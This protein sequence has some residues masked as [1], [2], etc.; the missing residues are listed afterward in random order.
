AAYRRRFQRLDGEDHRRTPGPSPAGSECACEAARGTR[1]TRGT[2]APASALGRVLVVLPNAAADRSEGLRRPWSF[3][4][5]IG[6]FPVQGLEQ[7]QA[8]GLPAAL[9]SAHRDF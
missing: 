9:D 5:Q 4:L 8:G 1:D 2:T 7:S 6:Q 3:S